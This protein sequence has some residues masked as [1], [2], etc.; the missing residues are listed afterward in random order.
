MK[1]YGECQYNSVRDL[2]LRVAHARGCVLVHVWG[3]LLSVVL[4][5]IQSSWTVCCVFSAGKQRACR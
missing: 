2:A 5:A 1:A 3:Q 4:K